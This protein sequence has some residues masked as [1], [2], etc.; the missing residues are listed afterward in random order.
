MTQMFECPSCG[1]SL[2]YQGDDDPVVRCAYCGT[3]FDT[4]LP[5]VSG[6]QAQV[7][8]GEQLAQVLGQ[9]LG[10]AQQWQ[11]KIGR[12]VTCVFVLM[13]L[14]MLAC[15]ILSVAGSSLLESVF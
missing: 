11:R 5:L 9:Q 12:F 15:L 10:S 6:E 13:L 7:V 3:T 4:S 14:A 1:A 2:E 8:S